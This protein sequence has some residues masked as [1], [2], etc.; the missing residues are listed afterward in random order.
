TRTSTTKYLRVVPGQLKRLRYG[1]RDSHPP[2]LLCCCLR[3]YGCLGNPFAA[4]HTHNV[5][6]KPLV[7]QPDASLP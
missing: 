2:F 7:E 3:H 6:E 5:E 1:S 4:P